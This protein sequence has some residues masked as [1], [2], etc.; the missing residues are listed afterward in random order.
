MAWQGR[1]CLQEHAVENQ[2]DSS[3]LGDTFCPL[4]KLSTFVF[5]GEITACLIECNCEGRKEGRA[6]SGGKEGGRR[7]FL[8]CLSACFN[9]KER[10]KEGK[11]GI[12]TANVHQSL[13]DGKGMG[14]GCLQINRKRLRV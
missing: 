10:R 1:G 7:G 3:L 9:Y 11:K 14:G 12:F 13:G 6:G 4:N 8:G 5:L 2:E